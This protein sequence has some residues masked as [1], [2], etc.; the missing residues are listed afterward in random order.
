MTL[1]L[2]LNSHQ[3]NCAN[4]DCEC[5][6]LHIDPY[7]TQETEIYVNTRVYLTQDSKTE[8]VKQ[9]VTPKI[10]QLILTDLKSQY[11]KTTELMI[12]SS[13]IQFYFLFNVYSAWQ[14]AK[15]LLSCNPSFILQ[16]RV[17]NLLKKISIGFEE[18]KQELDYVNLSVQYL[19]LHRKFLGELENCCELTS[20]LW[21]GL[22]DKNF[23]ANRLNHI[24]KSLISSKFKVNKIVES[25]LK[26]S[27]D[28]IEFLVRYGL[29]LNFI[30][31]NSHLAEQVYKRL[32][33]LL[34][35]PSTSVLFQ[36]SLFRTDESVM[37]MIINVKPGKSTV[38]YEVN[39]ELERVL[40]YKKSS[41]VGLSI[42][43]IMSPIVSEYHT[44][45]IQD[46]INTMDS[47]SINI[48]RVRLIKKPG[49]I[50]IPCQ[51]LKKIVPGITHGLQ[52]A[53][54]L[55]E[56]PPMLAY[57]ISPQDRG[58]EL[59]ISN[60][61]AGLILFDS[62]NNI[63]GFTK[64]IPL[65]LKSSDQLVKTSKVSEIFPQV[66]DSKYAEALSST[67]GM[68]IKCLNSL[69]ATEKEDYEGE[70]T[71][72][73]GKVL[74]RDY[75]GAKEFILIVAKIKGTKV[76]PRE[77]LKAA[78]VALNSEDDKSSFI[79]NNRKT[80][81]EI[82]EV[83]LKD[84]ILN[85]TTNVFKI[86]YFIIMGLLVII[87]VLIRI[88]LT[89]IV[90]LFL[91]IVINDTNRY[92]LDIKLVYTYMARYEL[93]MSIASA[94]RTYVENLRE[95]KEE[96]ETFI[97]RL[98]H[99][100]TLM[101]ARDKENKRLIHKGGFGYDAEPISIIDRYKDSLTVEFSHAIVTVLL[102]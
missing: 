54:F 37:V 48:P 35:N 31:H 98:T 39:T 49:D 93:I 62:N 88:L 78:N 17:Y 25:M 64:N 9:N 73:W 6:T 74:I 44:R 10:F 32:S 18:Y 75:G 71:Q 56:I 72:L 27:I 42:T 85:Q 86:L 20:Q 23:P 68:I 61:H 97:E 101:S 67:E 13:E 100:I 99:K 89:D 58:K 59:S 19:S 69:L 29:F 96:F 34:N 81:K 2:I 77:D 36:F 83:E 7:G 57:E 21:N 3:S 46:F 22:V 94:E 91:S 40:N 15:N 70:D 66:S 24:A 95:G 8:S 87:L 14:E 33:E 80:A 82:S 12:I 38:I 1:K 45:F 50:Y 84:V 65:L 90:A 28:H 79:G 30:S 92:I 47:K 16:Q 5:S 43:T 60:K 63:L 51:S 76:K 4:P 11:G 26:I 102:T 53:L 55:I 41:L 52:I